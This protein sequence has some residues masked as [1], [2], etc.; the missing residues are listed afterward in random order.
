MLVLI[1]SLGLSIY[2]NPSNVFAQSQSGSTNSTDN[3]PPILS[4]PADSVVEATNSSGRVIIYKVLGSDLVDG[5]IDVVCG[6]LS[7]SMFPIG[8]T[9]VSCKG[10]DKAGN[11]GTASFSI[12]VQDTTPPDTKIDF[13]RAGILGDILPNT[14]TS[15]SDISF[16]L[17]GSDNVGISHFECKLDEAKWISIVYDE[18]TMNDY[19]CIYTN[20]PSGV[21]T[22][23]ARS[24]DKAGNIDPMPAG[25]RWTV[26]SAYESIN[27]IM[28]KVKEIQLAPNLKDSM[29]VSLQKMSDGLAA[30]DL[31]KDAKIC[32]DIGAFLLAIKKT[33]MD[34]DFGEKFHL[35]DLILTLN[36]RIGC[37]PPIAN[38][39][40]DLSVDEGEKVH[41]DGSQS[42]GIYGETISYTWKQSSGPSAK[43]ANSHSVKPEFIA[44]QVDKNTNLKFELSVSDSHGLSSTDSVTVTVN[45]IIKPSNGESSDG[46]GGYQGEPSDTKGLNIA[47]VG[48]WG[49][50][51]NTQST[52]NNIDSK[53]PEVVLALGDY[54]YSSTATCWFNIIDPI[55]SITRITIGNHEDQ[56]SEDNS[57]YLN[58]FGL[59]QQ[60]YSFEY[61][62][63]HVITMNSEQNYDLG[64]SQYN[65]V[66]KDLES[67]SNNPNIHWIIVTFHQPAYSSPNSCSSCKA[68]TSIRDTYHPMFDQYGVDL[69]LE[70]H[71]HNYQRS[72][73]L[74]FNKND[75]SKPLVTNTDKNRYVDPKGPIFIIVGTGGINFHSLAGK[76]SYIVNQQDAKFGFLNIHFSDDGKLLG[77]TFYANDGSILDQF[78]VTKSSSAIGTDKIPKANSE[79]ISVE[80]D[81]LTIFS[82]NATDPKGG[83]LKYSILSQPSHGTLSGKTPS[84]TYK[85]SKDY[86]GQDSFTFKA[87]DDKGTDSN[88]ATVT[89][90]VKSANQAPVAED[91]SVSVDK[92]KPLQ[93][94]L[95]A[96]DAE[97]DPIVFA[98][99]SQPTNGVLSTFDANQGTVTYKPSKDYVGQDSFTFKAT[100]DKGTDS[101]IATVTM[102]VKSAN[103]APVAEDQ[104]VSVD[105]NKPLQVTLAA[106]DAEGD[107][108]VFALES[109]PTNGV[110][111][112]FDANQGT[113]T[114]KPSKDYV[115][116]DSFTFKAT[117][118]KGT[119]SNIA[120]VTM[121]VKS[122]NQAPV[123][124][125]Q[126]VSVDKNKP[127]QVTLAATDAEGDPIV[128]ALESQPTNGVLSTF[129]A[130][131]GTVTYKPS[132]DYVGQDSFTF[133]ATDDKGTDSNIATVTMDVKSANQAPVAEDQSVSV[134]KNK[135]L[136]V[137]LAA[138]D[139]EGDP[140]VFALESQPT[141]GVLSTFDANQGTVTYKPSKDYVGQDSFTFKATDDKGTDSNIATVTMDVKSANQAPVAE[142]G[143]NQEVEQ[144]TT[145]TLDGSNSTDP[146]N[147]S[148]SYT[149][150]QLSGPLVT[151]VNPDAAIIEFVAPQVND[152]TTLKFKLTVTDQ[153]GEKGSKRI[154]VTVKNRSNETATELSDPIREIPKNNELTLPEIQSPSDGTVGNPVPDPDTLTALIK[155][156]ETGLQHEMILKS[157][158]NTGDQVVKSASSYPKRPSITLQNGFPIILASNN[159]DFTISSTEVILY[160]KNDVPVY[161][162]SEGG[163]TL[164]ARCANGHLQVR[165]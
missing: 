77:G 111:S 10:A 59:S 73:P 31:A 154:D 84:V 151:L 81:K 20:I 120:T 132:K 155:Q 115:G 47:A 78:S 93:V 57:A 60:Y 21:H 135:P 16:K 66:K 159:P 89:M 109:Q 102:D 63:V 65:F 148:L 137:T 18:N 4:V 114:Y 29:V 15:S 86:V 39:G 32:S 149:W 105:K 95:A 52:G 139:A 37:P 162:R 42:S 117:D 99:E 97:G 50:N 104:S 164:D 22:V 74:T 119:D 100:D 138:T 82:L 146:N 161:L 130:N 83:P 9:K 36:S 129:D 163:N 6:P 34:V 33:A 19:G 48:D 3:K 43:L 62:D 5:T 75:P 53:N 116:Q 152:D 24:V 70:G 107:P 72:Y 143:S 1:S 85:P 28:I 133:K 2:S 14:N 98:L 123:A 126:S 7:G 46:G 79:A 140:I 134:D 150:E 25:F 144:G 13:A 27:N 147:D 131:Q 12:K 121:D 128:F 68:A 76:E 165:S 94:T 51:S 92:N 55:G 136:Q 58:H 103:Q 45:D 41:L 64:S 87:T 153:D 40:K 122:A 106:T 69:V 96:T 90:D 67:A 124:E 158:S 157:Y 26:L 145:V 38:A 108:I 112:T 88:I 11:V 80:K 127:L 142:T 141:N 44:P 23:L 35:M 56:P 49:C 54:S 17:S 125:D 8:K 110:L 156:N 101:N 61:Q 71:V 160:D 91:Q 113:V 118:D 30:E